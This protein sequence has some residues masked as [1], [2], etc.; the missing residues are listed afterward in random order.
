[1][2][3]LVN[4]FFRR[5]HTASV[6]GRASWTVTVHGGVVGSGRGVGLVRG[7]RAWRARRVEMMV[8]HVDSRRVRYEVDEVAICGEWGAEEVSYKAGGKLDVGVIRHSR[9][10]LQHLVVLQS[11]GCSLP[12]FPLRGDGP[13]RAGGRRKGL[14]LV[15]SPTGPPSWAP[16]TE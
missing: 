2:F 16:R 11:T 14:S 5:E 13:R 6:A 3:I 8:E 4:C 15:A 1:M 9:E 7:E 10:V 12:R